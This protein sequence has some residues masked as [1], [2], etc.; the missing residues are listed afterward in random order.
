MAGFI[1]W[2]GEAGLVSAGVRSPCSKK[3]F[4][5]HTRRRA[6]DAGSDSRLLS[7]SSP[8]A[9][10]TH[11]GGSQGAAAGRNDR[12]PSARSRYTASAQSNLKLE[13]GWMSQPRPT[14]PAT[15]PRPS[16]S[17]DHQNPGR[18]AIV[19]SDLST[20]I[21]GATHH[22]STFSGESVVGLQ[23]KERL[24]LLLYSRAD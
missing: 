2:A 20:Q 23:T 15:Q 11:T 8:E 14:G 9:H 6:R 21:H 5:L 16:A 7:P 17:A 10:T 3:D 19:A 13:P 12:S 18:H 4:D 22:S 1:V 24:P